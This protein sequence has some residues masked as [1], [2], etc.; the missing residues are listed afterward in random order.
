MA[1]AGLAGVQVPVDTTRYYGYQQQQMGAH[2]EALTL[3][4]RGNRVE[5]VVRRAGVFEAVQD[6]YSKARMINELKAHLSDD[7]AVVDITVPK[8]VEEFIGFSDPIVDKED[9]IAQA[10]VIK[11]MSKNVRWGT[12]QSICG[13][14]LFIIVCLGA[15]G[16]FPVSALA[17]TVIGLGAA[18]G[19][20]G[21]VAIGKPV[22]KERKVAMVVLAVIAALVV[23]LG[24]LGVSGVLTAKQVSWGVIGTNLASLPIMLVLTGYLARNGMSMQERLRELKKKELGLGE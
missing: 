21:L 4:L 19:I 8:S 11:D 14:A 7:E 10:L 13:I 9:M 12:V 16:K 23:T 18:G 1:S 24:V 3:V 15:A 22:V 2:V 20:F 6:M 17:P 5:A